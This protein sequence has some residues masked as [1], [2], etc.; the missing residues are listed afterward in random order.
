VDGWVVDDSTWIV[1]S[2]QLNL[3]R[4]DCEPNEMSSVLLALSCRRRDLHHKLIL[5]AQHD[6]RERRAMVSSSQQPS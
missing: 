6:R 5:S 1:Q 4:F 3:A 2:V